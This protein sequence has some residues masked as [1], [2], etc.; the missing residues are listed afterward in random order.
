VLAFIDE[1]CDVV[2]TAGPEEQSKELRELVRVID[3]PS[4]ECVLLCLEKNAAL[5]SED[6]GLRLLAGQAGVSMSSA[7]QPVWMVACERRHLD[8]KCYADCLAAKILGNHDFVSVNGRDL[9]ELASGQPQKVHPAIRAAF[10]TFR[11]PTLELLSGVNVCVEFLSL[12]VRKLPPSTAGTYAGMAMGAL[13]HGRAVRRRVFDRV[14]ASRL[15]VYGRNG[16]RLPPYLRRLFGG[17][18]SRHHLRR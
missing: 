15:S 13:L 11:R 12:A 4:G 6:G 1:H 2:A 10:E 7:L 5:L 18:L 3:D 14:F 17:I 16:R 9:M 8:Q